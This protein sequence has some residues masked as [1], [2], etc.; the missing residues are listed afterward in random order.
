MLWCAS[1]AVVA[2]AGACS[3]SCPCS[4]HNASGVS[5]FAGAWETALAAR[6]DA[7]LADLTYA[8][9]AGAVVLLGAF[10]NTLDPYS[11]DA[12]A[13][14]TA[15]ATWALNNSLDGLDFT[16]P[17]L[18]QGPCAKAARVPWPLAEI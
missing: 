2:A 18:S 8:H 14:G 10:G 1:I 5:Q 17:P 11:S 9:D 16:P 6:P 3:C 4:A 15:A 12:V 13:Y 7:I